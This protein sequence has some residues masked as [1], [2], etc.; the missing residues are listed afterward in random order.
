[1]K[2]KVNQISSTEYME[3]GARKYVKQI[4]FISGQRASFTACF[5][6]DESEEGDKYTLDSEFEL[7]SVNTK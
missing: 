2:F 4:S 6:S 3:N 7:V 5:N 1:M